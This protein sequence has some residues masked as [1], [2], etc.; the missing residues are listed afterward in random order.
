M[1]GLMRMLGRRQHREGDRLSGGGPSAHCPEGGRL[2][3]LPR[4]APPAKRHREGLVFM[5]YGCLCW[6]CLIAVVG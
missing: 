3:A 4:D 6:R 5:R 1:G 2:P